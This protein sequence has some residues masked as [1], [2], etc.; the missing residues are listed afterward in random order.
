M[1]TKAAFPAIPAPVA[2]KRHFT[3]M[4]HGITRSD[5]YAWLRAENWQEVFRDPS[6]LDPAI[7]AHLEAENAYQAQMTAETDA[8]RK[9]LFAEMKARIKEDDSTVPEKDGPFAY[10]MSYTT[11]GEH[12]RFFRTPREGGAELIYLDGDRESEGKAYFRIGG[13][14]R[15]PDHKRLVWG[16]DDKGSEFY[17]LKVRD[18]ESLA[19]LGDFVPDTGGGGVFDAKG[20]GF[21]YTRLDPNHRPSK[22]LYHRIGT[23]TD[24]DRLVYEEA[25]AGFFMGVSGSRLDDFIFIDIHD[26]ETS[27]SLARAGHRPACRPEAGGKARNRRRIRHDGGR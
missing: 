6:V 25:D 18:V 19:D 17:T 4:R 27:E 21:F 9:T 1:P 8:L 5:D 13:A 15:S 24:D 16:Y 26:H 14:D 23:P 12:P 7:R 3:D 22:L 10:G 20:E 11:G 2:A